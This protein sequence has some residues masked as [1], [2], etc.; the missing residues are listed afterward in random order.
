MSSALQKEKVRW[1][2]RVRTPLQWISGIS[3]EMS[4]KEMPKMKLNP[5]LGI[6]V[7]R[8]CG[9][10]VNA[11]ALRPELSHGPTATKS[12]CLYEQGGKS[13][14]PRSG[15]SRKSESPGFVGHPMVE[16]YWKLLRK[17]WRGEALK[18]T[19]LNHMRAIQIKPSVSSQSI[20]AI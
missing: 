18:E 11:K 4:V 10:R 16:S 19:P 17:A 9:W 15:G 20:P 2:D 6:A 8:G 12:V 13:E 14:K 3:E 5:S 1:G 7:E